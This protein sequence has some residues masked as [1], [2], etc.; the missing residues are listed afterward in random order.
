MNM[1]P[2]GQTMQD[3][4]TAANVILSKLKEWEAEAAQESQ[5]DQDDRTGEAVM[6]EHIAD[7]IAAA[8]DARLAKWRD[9]IRYALKCV[10]AEW[11][12]LQ[13]L[14]IRNLEKL[15]EES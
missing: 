4:L 14:W 1:M 6:R 11:P 7:V 12:A 8:V 2:R 10:H 15:L 13:A 3:A 9:V 5:L